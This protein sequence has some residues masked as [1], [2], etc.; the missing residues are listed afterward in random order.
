MFIDFREASAPAHFEY[1]LCI[2]GAGAAGITMARALTDSGIRVCVLESGGFEQEEATQNLYAGE[3]A[4]LTNADPLTCR[5]RTFGGTTMHWGG[6][7]APLQEHDFAVRSWVPDSGW[8]IK[9]S[10][11]VPWYEQAQKIVEIGPFKYGA[12]AFLQ[13]KYRFPTFHPDKLDVGFFQYSPPTRFGTVYKDELG[14]AR[15]VDIVLHANVTHIQ[16]DRSASRITQLQIQTLEGR[17]GSVT[18]K[19]FVMACGGMENARLLLLANEIQ[20]NGLGNGNGLVGK[21]FLQHVEIG[22]VARIIGKDLSTLFDAFRRYTLQEATVAA[23]IRTS[24]KAQERSGYLNCAFTMLETEW[25]DSA[26]DKTGY[27]SL[28]DAWNQLNSGHLRDDFRKQ[29][30]S[31]VTDLDSAVEG[32]YKQMRG[33]PYEGDLKEVV[34]WARCEQSPNRNSSIG[35]GSDVDHFGQRKIKVNWQLTEFDKRSVR[36]GL[37]TVAEELGRLNLGRM[38]VADWLMA[39]D[40]SWAEPVWGGCHH[41]GTTRMSDDPKKGVVDRNCRMHTV[42]NLYIAGSSVFPTTGYVPPTLTIVSLA[43]RLADHL[44]GKQLKS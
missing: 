21:Y 10:E 26:W 41:M 22:A 23:E 42:Q 15:N 2:I 8:P 11:L 38:Q 40:T 5:L 18:A 24:V 39:D 37:R 12:D 28:K 1:D 29:L 25:Q 34:L 31:V 27:N 33:L 14:R 17:K 7:C 16:T 30:W 13:D 6:W 44:K 32:T 20:K 4:G 19:T 35:L 36:S 43:L 9:Y 3:T